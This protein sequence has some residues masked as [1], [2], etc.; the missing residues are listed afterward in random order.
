MELKETIKKISEANFSLLMR[1]YHRGTIVPFIGSGFSANISSN[2]F[3]QWKKFLIEYAQQL[4]IKKMIV[5]IL[6]DINIPF[7]YELAATTLANHDAA[8]TE[9]IQDFFAL[10][11]TDKLDSNAIIQQLPMIFPE[12]PLLTSNLDTVIETVYKD[13]GAP[14]DQVLYGMTFTDE[15]LWRITSSKEHV[16][17]KVHGCIKDK[18]TV[19]FSEYQY[20]KLYGRLNEN[21]EYMSSS[22]KKFPGRFKKMANEIRFLFLGCSLSEDRYLEILKQV[23][24]Q[25]KEDANYHFAIIGAPKD[26]KEFIERQQYLTSCGIAPIWYEAGNHEQIREYLNRLF[27]SNRKYNFISST[28]TRIN[29]SDISHFFLDPIAQIAHGNNTDRNLAKAILCQSNEFRSIMNETQSI[30]SKL[31]REV[32][33]DN[34]NDHCPLII[35]GKPGT[36]KSTLLSLLFLNIPKPL[37]CYTALID[38]HSYDEEKF[39]QSS[40]IVPDFNCILQFI[41]AEINSHNSSILFIDGLNGYVRMNTE[42]EILLIGKIKEWSR[43]GKVRFVFSIG[44][45]DSNQFPPFT[46]VSDPILFRPNRTIELSPIDATTEEFSFLIE[47]VLKTLSIVPKL[48]PSQKI[49]DATNSL[50]DNIITLCKKISGNIVEFRTAV[51]VA[52]RYDTYKDDL[53]KLDTGRVLSEFFIS[54]M[55]EK[56]LAETSEHIALFMLKKEEQARPWTNSV[57]FKSPAFR[58]FFFAIHYINV[59]ETGEEDKINF[60]DCIFTPSINRFIVSILNQDQNREYKITCNLIIVF[61]KL[62]TKAKNQAVYL[63]GRVK[64]P[65]SKK[66]TIAFLRK[67]YIDLKKSL[68][69][70]CN[71]D[72][73]DKIMLFRSVAI[74][75][76]YLGNREYEDEF[77]SLLIYNEK[78]RDINLMFHVTYYTTDAYKV[79]QDINVNC[80]LLCTVQNMENLYYFLLHSIKTTTE[81]GRQG[82]NIIT[83]ISL[84]IYQMYKNN[85]TINKAD[86]TNLIATLGNDMSITSP[87]LKRYIFS[88]KDHLDETNIYSSS[89]SRL[90]SMKT[91]ERA[92]WLERGR[93]IYK[94]RRVESDADHTWGCCLLAQILLAD[95]IEDCVFLSQDD[96]TKYATDYSKNKIINML[97]VH[98]LPEIYTGDTP[99]GKQTEDKEEKET[100][101]MQMIAALDSFPFFKSFHSMEQLWQE[102]N[103]KTSINATLA[104]QIDKLEPLVQLYIYRSALPENQRRYQLESWVQK[105]NEQL[106][107]C[108]VQTSFGSNVLEF[109]SKYLL[110]EDFFVD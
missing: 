17:L 16:L 84:W 96:K 43:S 20:S 75:L 38:L 99:V 24:G 81:R 8:F 85:T 109:L 27:N 18:D 45:L 50:L 34:S 44:D 57:V 66:K 107:M 55:N 41:E 28:E 58:D 108:K 76:I 93:E 62:G 31:C 72:D 15:Q 12:S 5:D 21:R 64:N 6:E 53:F 100:M 48:K 11:E 87:V 10:K 36:G 69:Q 60:F 103:T 39:G 23:K 71:D 4:G 74:S 54:N 110:G 67:Q 14:I 89:I 73:S 32:L 25:A 104:Y 42:R 82:V 91:I 47:K 106:S 9:K 56:L 94:K 30:L 29:D 101:S 35:R 7:R 3:P 59:V 88:I 61:E 86:F 40:M 92:G 26:E 70:F 37:G 13:Q 78:I 63:L 49:S 1:Y 51:F 102:Y 80:S 2:K 77:F 98:D 83:L 79:G 90:Y 65:Q 95:K 22:R 46:R 52:K 105:A 33:V 19:V 68:D 97:L